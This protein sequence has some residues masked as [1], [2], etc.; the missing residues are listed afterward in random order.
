V[1][2][3]KTECRN[4]IFAIKEEGIQIGCRFNRLDKFPKVWNLQHKSFVINRLC[5]RCRDREWL[6]KHEEADV[7]EET[8][9]RVDTILFH[10]DELAIKFLKIIGVKEI[11]APVNKKD[12]TE[13][14]FKLLQSYNVKIIETFYPATQLQ[15]IDEAVRKIKSRYYAILHKDIHPYDFIAELQDL[16]EEQM[17]HVIYLDKDIPI[18]NTNVHKYLGGNNTKTLVEKIKETY[19]SNILS[20]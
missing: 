11:F 8:K 16:V 9:V 19:E 18:F 3:I 7:L 14:Q 17:I 2:K 4:C 1:S 15:L 10:Y 12:L 6:N 13:E 20:S 5:T